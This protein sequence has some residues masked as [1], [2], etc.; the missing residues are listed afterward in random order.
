MMGGRARKVQNGQQN[1]SYEDTTMGMRRIAADAPEVATVPVDLDMSIHEVA[2]FTG[3]DQACPDPSGAQGFRDGLI[4]PSGSDF[5]VLALV[6]PEQTF[7][8]RMGL[9]AEGIEGKRIGHFPSRE[10]RRWLDLF[11]GRNVKGILFIDVPSASVQFRFRPGRIGEGPA[12]APSEV[13]SERCCGQCGR[14]LRSEVRFCTRC[15][16][17]VPR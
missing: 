15:G 3:I 7:G 14:E 13:S 10:R 6:Y 1:V 16:S 2:W 9:P 8:Y 12:P 4:M 17:P 5:L 11:E